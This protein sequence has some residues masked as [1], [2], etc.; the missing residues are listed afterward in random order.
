MNCIDFRLN[1]WKSYSHT[2]IN[3]QNDPMPIVEKNTRID[4]PIEMDSMMKLLCEKQYK[5]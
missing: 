3:F 2:Q 4:V 5:L 1:V